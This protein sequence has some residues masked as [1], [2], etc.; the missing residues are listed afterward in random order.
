MLKAKYAGAVSEIYRLNRDLVQELGRIMHDVNG[1][2]M[3]TLN[4]ARCFSDPV[5]DTLYEPRYRL[6]RINEDYRAAALAALNSNICMA[7]MLG[8]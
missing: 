6:D 3:K 2:A 7:M 5:A 1:P 4:K 8:V